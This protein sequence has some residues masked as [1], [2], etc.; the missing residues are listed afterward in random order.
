MKFTF[1]DM[2]WVAIIVLIVIYLSKCHRDNSGKLDDSIK[3]LQDKT[4]SDSVQH[5]AQV[6]LYEARIAEAQT[7]S[8]KYSEENKAIEQQLDKKSATVLRLSAAL[9]D[10]K[11][12]DT[13][14]IGVGQ[15]YLDYCDSLAIES[16]N[17][18]VNFANYKRNNGYIITAKNL[19]ITAK[20]SLLDIKDKA[21]QS[22]KADYNALMHF[23]KQSQKQ[24]KPRNQVYVGAE[25][26]A[27]PHYLVSNVGVAL[28]LKTKDN[29]LWQLSG[30]IQTNGQ[31][32]IRVNGNILIKLKR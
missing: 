1:R 16:S 28:T 11:I 8:R 32:Y 20:D 3:E 10:L 7:R 24:L 4:R 5:A 6:R 26:M 12:V 14:V 25:I 9:K 2:V 13:N 27:N 17:L 19:E 18:V 22:C 30:G 15:E 21:Y 29:K 31:Y 23:Y